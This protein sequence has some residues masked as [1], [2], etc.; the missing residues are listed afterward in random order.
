[1]KPLGWICQMFLF[2]AIEFEAMLLI[3]ASLLLYSAA[4]WDQ[5]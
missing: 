5:K 2:E 3:P 4:L 1:M